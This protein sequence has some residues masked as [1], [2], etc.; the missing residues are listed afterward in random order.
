MEGR[1]DGRTNLW[2]DGRMQSGEWSIVCATL[3]VL[4][5]RWMEGRMDAAYDV[6]YDGDYGRTGTVQLWMRKEIRCLCC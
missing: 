6:A 2:M 5:G 1:M 4:V 3:P